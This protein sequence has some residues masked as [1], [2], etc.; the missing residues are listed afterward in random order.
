MD[1]SGVKEE[2]LWDTKALVGLDKLAKDF[3]KADL[4]KMLTSHSFMLSMF[5]KWDQYK[6]EKIISRLTNT[7]YNALLLEYLNMRSAE[8]HAGVFKPHFN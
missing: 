3:V 2:R 7:K 6:T 4:D 5:Q 1:T 8:L